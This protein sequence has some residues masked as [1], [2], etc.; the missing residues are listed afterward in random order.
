V[1]P[2]ALLPL[3]LTCLACAETANRPD[4]GPPMAAFPLT[5][6][7]G[8]RRVTI[9]LWKPSFSP[10]ASKLAVGRA[11]AG[12]EVVELATGAR[13]KLTH[14]GQD[15][16]WSPDGRFI[17]FSSGGKKEEVW[18]V[19]PL[20]AQPPRRIA[21]GGYPSWSADGKRLFFVSH[22]GGQ[23]FAVSIDDPAAVPSLFFGH[24][25]AWYPAVSPDESRV[26]M[27][28]DG[29]V[30]VVER[31]SGTEVSRSAVGRGGG[32]VS[33][34]PDGKWVAYG[35]FDSNGVWLYQPETREFHVVVRGPFTMPTFSRD[36]KLLA[37]DQRQTGASDV[38]VTDRFDLA[39]RPRTGT[40]GRGA[41]VISGGEPSWR[42][43]KM[44][45]AELD[46]RDL[47]GHLW[48]LQQLDGKVAFIN[49]WATWCGPCI[50][51]LPLVQ[52]LHDSLKGRADTLVLSLNVDDDPDKARQYAAEHKLTFP[53]LPANKYVSKVL[54]PSISIP[55]SWIVGGGLLTAES[56]GFQGRDEAWLEAARAQIERA[57]GKGK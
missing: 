31:Q 49:V 18:V 3:L 44:P 12:I 6:K 15:P 28:L 26:A 35:L 42:W 46:L 25:D 38:W 48:K 20:A 43:R 23:I 1:K 13:N 4:P 55:R 5:A 2:P 41:G 29:E 7:P 51:E 56:M 27:L 10:D 34:S 33:W 30:I 57:R 22:P 8:L 36:A 24:V 17:A 14:F 9:G 16:S 54:G 50:K 40:I 53:V 39:P 19:D 37:F 32:L 45:M 21:V 52:K 47:G 11:D